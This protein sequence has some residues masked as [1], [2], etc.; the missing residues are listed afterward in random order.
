[1]M[2]LW[3]GFHVIRVLGPQQVAILGGYE[4]FGRWKATGQSELLGGGPSRV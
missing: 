3:V 2:L 1:M 4:I